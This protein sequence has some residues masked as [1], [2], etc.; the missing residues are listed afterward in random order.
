MSEACSTAAEPEVLPRG[1]RRTPGFRFSVADGVAIVAAV[2]AAAALWDAVGAVALLP[3][4]VLGHFFLFCNV[5]RVRRGYELA[6]A[7]V[8][9]VN[10]AGWCLTGGFTWAGVLLV[11]TPVTVA[12]VVAEV[13]GSGYHGVGYVWVR[14]RRTRG[15]AGVGG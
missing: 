3:P 7:A 5:F 10:V 15:A 9:V 4:V 1:R 11:Q 14:R 12:C 2:G 6:W 8:F 13:C